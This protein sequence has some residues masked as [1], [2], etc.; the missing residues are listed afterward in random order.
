MPEKV[1]IMFFTSFLNYFLLV[2]TRSDSVAWN[3]RVPEKVAK[4][5]GKRLKKKKYSSRWSFECSLLLGNGLKVWQFWDVLVRRELKNAAAVE[6]L[7]GQSST[8]LFSPSFCSPSP[9]WGD[10]DGPKNWNSFPTP[11]HTLLHVCSWVSPS[12]FFLLDV[13]FR[14]A[15]LNKWL[16]VFQHQIV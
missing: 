7:C 13:L 11:S 16:G 15:V 2:Y 14:L 5:L 12:S 3:Q 4:F 1:S 9:L 10:V 8:W 6:K